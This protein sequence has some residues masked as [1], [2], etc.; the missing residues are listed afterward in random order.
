MQPLIMGPAVA[1]HPLAV[2]LAI[3]A[4]VVAPT[5]RRLRSA[6]G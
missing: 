2:I 1:L 3:T 5:S 4:G 6:A